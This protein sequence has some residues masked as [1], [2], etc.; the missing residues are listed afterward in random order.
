VL[1][2]TAQNRGVISGQ[3]EI[4]ACRG[5]ATVRK[6]RVLLVGPSLRILGGQAV[7]AAQLLSRMRQDNSVEIDFLAVN[8][9]L[10]GWLGKLQDIK[11]VRTAVTSLLYLAALLS[12]VPKYQ[13]LHIFSASYSSFVLA[14][15]PAILVARLY[16][17]RTILNYRSGQA[18]DHLQK[19]RR[20]AIPTMRLVDRII[21][22]SGYLV[23]VFAR[24]RL[25]AGYIYNIVDTERFRFRERSPLR[26]V[27]FANR[28]LEPLYNVDCILRAFSRIQQRY[29]EAC[30]VVAGDGSQRRFLEDLARELDLRNTGFVGRIPH[31]QMPAFYDQADIYLNSPNIDNM[32]GSIIEAYA[33]GLPVVST[34]AGGIPYIVTDQETGLLVR[35]GDF[36]GLAA[37]AIRYLS[38]EGLAQRIARRA[39][40]EC[41]KYSW[42]SVRNQWLGVYQELI[43]NC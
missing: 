24:F 8:P 27:F 22:P 12:H 15:T 26:P 39:R 40:E 5:G 35:C 2:V 18:E 9:R 29:P 25:Q 7:Q 43:G 33:S 16:G 20:T 4:E 6:P 17:K 3:G 32:P 23:D 13:V 21:V 10:P 1:P 14:P 28:N 11:Y 42:E 19:W 34:D 38:E 31:D 36:D 41:H 37:A 30:L